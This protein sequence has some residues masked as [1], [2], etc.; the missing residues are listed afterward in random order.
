M[1]LHVVRLSPPKIGEFV[2]MSK[3]GG[4]RQ[5]VQRL[6]GKDSST[7]VVSEWIGRNDD[8]ANDR[9]IFDLPKPSLTRA[10]KFFVEV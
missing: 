1:P 10:F 9:Q 6:N 2:E 4:S 5:Q 8:K 7:R 3:E